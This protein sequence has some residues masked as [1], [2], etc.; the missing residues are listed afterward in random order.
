VNEQDEENENFKDESSF[1]VELKDE[2]IPGYFST[3]VNVAFITKSVKKCYENES[4]DDQ[5][6][7]QLMEIDQK[8]NELKLP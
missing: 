8:E 5:A 4:I 6:I 7:N 3:N 1:F 2:R